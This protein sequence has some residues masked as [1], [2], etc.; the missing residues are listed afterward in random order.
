VTQPQKFDAIII[1]DGQAGGPLSTALVKAGRKTAVIEREYAGGTCINTGCTPTK[2]MIASARVAYL[3]DR[4]PDYGVHTGHVSTD[5]GAVRQRKRDIVE[6]FRESS[7]S[8][9]EEGGAEFL[10]GEGHFTGT[11]TVDVSLKTGETLHLSAGAIFLDTGTRPHIPKLPGLDSAP[12]LTSTT[13]MELDQIPEH[14]I[15]MGGGYIGLEFGQMFRR[16]GSRVTIVEQAPRLVMQEDEDVSGAVADVLR[17]DGIEV[18]TE[19]TVQ[20]VER[21]G[22]GSLRLTVKSQDGERALTGSHLLVAVG[23]IPNTE[24]LR[25]DAAGVN[26]TDKGFIAVNNRLETN[27][28]GI[29]AMGEVAGSPP[30]THISYDDFRIVRDNLLQGGS[31]T[32]T[33][34]LVP[35]TMFI[36]PQLGRVGMS[37]TQAREKGR[38][39]KVA[40]MPMSQVARAIEVDETRGMVKV[41]VDSGTSQILGA[42]VL[43]LEGGEIMAMLEIAMMGK[44]PYQAL[45]SGIFAHPTLA[46]LLNSVFGSLDS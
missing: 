22:E 37:E 11:R 42:A 7:K 25:L 34:R 14:L 2:T 40:A 33:D 45:Q 39:I 4:A 6:S 13:I 24:H 12:Y 9:V 32:T 26:K 16:F 35:Y 18:L 43:G 28:P 29:Y 31:R 8:A 21:R 23:R 27:V 1:G 36:D 3:A 17:E 30:F 5:L 15:I 44:L 10:R 41:V 46:E 20:S 38:D 19:T